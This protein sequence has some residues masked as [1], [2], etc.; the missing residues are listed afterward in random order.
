MTDI[1]TD[2]ITADERASWQANG[3]FIRRGFRPEVDCY[4]TD[5]PSQLTVVVALPG[6]DPD[7]IEI[8]ATARTI[9]VTGERRRDRVEGAVYQQ[10]EIEYGPFQRRIPL[11]EPVDAKAASA[12]YDQG[13]LIVTLPIA[14]RAPQ[15]ER[16][17]I[18][19]RGRA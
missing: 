5:E 10:M 11:D 1:S 19:I 4:V 8:A 15:A 16:V 7:A 13:M 3:F 2:P 6:V 18:V 17:A 9:A 12:R 14:P